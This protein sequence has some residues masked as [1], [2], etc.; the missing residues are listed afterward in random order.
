LSPDVGGACDAV[1]CEYST[2]QERT[3]S[4]QMRFFHGALTITALASVL[5]AQGGQRP[6]PAGQGAQQVQQQQMTAQ[7]T[8][9][10]QQMQETVQRMS[11]IQQRAQ[12]LAAA[13][14]TQTQARTQLGER[15]R[16][17]L[18]TCDALEQQARQ[19]HQ[20]GARAQEMMRSREFA[21]DREMQRDMDQLR[22][23]LHT[24]ASEMDETLQLMERVRQR[25]RTADPAAPPA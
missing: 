6:N 3:M 11:Q 9:L 17:M 18:G 8:R 7:Q 22:R 14:R 5:G 10:S 24:M 23:R 21:G 15:E 19:M 16:L 25:T 1:R 2:N 13:M 12:T 20:L 4:I